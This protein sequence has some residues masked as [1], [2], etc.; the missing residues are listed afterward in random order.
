M[1][2]YPRN[3]LGNAEEIFNCRLSR[4][5]KV[6]EFSLW[7]IYSKV[8]LIPKWIKVHP[9]KVDKSVKCV[10]ILHNIIINRKKLKDN[11]KSPENII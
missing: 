3:G 10:C 5:R 9:E 11:R 4:A 2:S 8:E 6:E 7:Y 1:R